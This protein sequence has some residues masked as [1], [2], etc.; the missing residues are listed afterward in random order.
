MGDPNRTLCLV[1][2]YTFAPLEQ[3]PQTCCVSLNF[4]VIIRE[5]NVCI[6]IYIYMY[7]IRCGVK[8][9]KHLPINTCH[10]DTVVVN[11]LP[12]ILLQINPR[13]LPASSANHW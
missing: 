9:S 7:I 3:L 12:S 2:F 4:T 11:L 8:N 5:K 1:A 6:C 10:Y 13:V